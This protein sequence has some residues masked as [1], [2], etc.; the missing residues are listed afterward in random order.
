MRLTAWVRRGRAEEL[1]RGFDSAAAALASSLDPEQEPVADRL[2]G[3]GADLSGSGRWGRRRRGARGVYV[4]GP[5][6]RGKTWLVDVLLAQLPAEDALR[7]HAY[8]AAR[9]LHREVARSAGRGVAVDRAVDAILDGVRLLF[10]DELH[11]HDPGDAMLLSRLVRGLPQ[12]G[13]VLVATSNYAPDGLLPDPRHHHLV[14]PL[15]RALRDSCDVLELAGP[16]DHRALGEGGARP[17]WSSGAWLQPGSGAQLAALGLAVPTIGDRV[18]LQVGGRPLWALHEQDGQVQLSFAELCEGRTS[19][20][21]LLELADRY[22]TIVV[23]GIPLLADASPDARRRFAD[24][25]DV[26]WDRDVRLVVL[27]RHDRVQALDAQLTDRERVTS[28]LQLLGSG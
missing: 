5:V 13:C 9:R 27:A 15:I 20:G 16:V 17:G 3:L 25:V 6:G 14:L 26:C 22:R 11:A 7:L 23:A 4:H 24:L 28:R 19:V 2:A 12:R 10:L 8:Q 18:R 1:R 21:D